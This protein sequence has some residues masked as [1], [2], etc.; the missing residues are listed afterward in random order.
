MS[1]EIPLQEMLMARE[2]RFYRQQE[3]LARYPMTMISFT[4]NIA[5]PVKNSALIRRGFDHGRTLLRRMLQAARLRPAHEEI[6]RAETGDEAY[7]M[8]NADPAVIKRLTVA[9]E[10][11]SFMAR[12]YDM[13]VLNATGAKIDRA[14]LGLPTRHCL[15]CSNEAKACARSR[16]HTVAELQA[17]TNELLRNG[18]ADIDADRIA[19]LSVRALLY[20]VTTTPKPGLVDRTNTGSHKDMDMFTF[21]RSAAALFPYFRNCALIGIRD[22]GNGTPAPLTLALLREPGMLAEGAMLDATGGVNTH[23]GAIFSIGI[24]AAALGRVSLEERRNPARVLQ[25]CAAIAAG[26]TAQ[27]YASI[28]RNE[29]AARAD[30]AT[31]GQWLYAAYGLT[32]V[33][34]QAEAGFP[35]VLEHGLPVLEQGLA[36]GLSLD[37]AG[38]AAMLSML[39][40]DD[41]TNMIG[42]GGRDR[43][44]TR[45]AELQALL[46]ENPY[47]PLAAFEALDDSYIAENLSP[48]G[49]ADLLAL[50][51]LLYFWETEN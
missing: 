21:M 49:S 39:A 10:D 26:L 23:K 40:V 36:Q 14:S 43:Q 4:M 31:V 6:L 11:G 47:P 35:A 46:V 12:L 1:R 16:T 3:L 13:D 19:E 20:E 27:D 32:G 44:L 30:Y 38:A 8:V 50:C 2:A 45:V 15:I 41:D 24:A 17:R 37:Q 42:R 7:Y 25:E 33:R 51:Y 18:L 28:T 29:S 9:I 5:G 34:G 48:G 22:A